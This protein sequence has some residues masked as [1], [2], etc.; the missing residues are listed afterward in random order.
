MRKKEKI[1]TSSF[2]V[3]DFH[4]EETKT[5]IIL[6]FNHFHP[7]IELKAFSERRKKPFTIERFMTT[8]KAILG[9]SRIILARYADDE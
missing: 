5:K 9:F 2:E 6:D 7:H 8:I 1:T 3:L 4:E